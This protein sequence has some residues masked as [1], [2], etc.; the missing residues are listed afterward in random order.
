M[1]KRVVAKTGEFQNAQNKTKGEYT[2]LGV[3]LSN[4][5][6]EYMLLDPTVSLAGVLAKQN[7]YAVKQGKPVR[8]SVMVSFFSDDNQQQQQTPQQQQYVQPNGQPMNPQQVQQQNMGQPQQQQY[9][10]QGFQG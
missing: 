6:G 5:N 4:E 9:S 1:T 8:D 10:P 3:V 2:R 7:A